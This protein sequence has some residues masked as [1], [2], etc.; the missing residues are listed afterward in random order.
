MAGGN[1][2]QVD[3]AELGTDANKFASVRRAPIVPRGPRVRRNADPDDVIESEYELYKEEVLRS[4]RGK[5]ASQKI[6]YAALD[7][8]GFYNQAWHTVYMMLAEGEEVDNR[9]G[10]LVTVAYRRA[11]DEFRAMHPDRQADVDALDVLSSETDLDAALDDRAKLHQFI[12]S[13]RGQL[14]ERELQ[15]AGLCYVYGY[16]RPEAAEVI[17]VRPQRMEKIM[18]SVSK[19]ISPFVSDIKAG[20]WCEAQSSLMN[21]YAFGLLDDDTVRYSLAVEHLKEC[22]A[23]RSD[24]LRKRGIAALV[25]PLPFLVIAGKAGAAVGVGGATAG[26]AAAGHSGGA[27]GGFSLASAASAVGVVGAVG[28]MTAAVVVSRP[29]ADSAKST[30]E[31]PAQLPAAATVI[32]SRSKAAVLPKKVHKAKK[33]KRKKHKAKAKAVQP[34]PVNVQQQPAAVTPEPVQQPVQQ[35]A[36]QKSQPKSPSSTDDGAGEF[37]LK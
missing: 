37:D 33:P 23:C 1:F 6:R 8:D 21:A 5:L 24:V 15:A 4:L 3:G 10:M 2:D 22:P 7:L 9:R 35:P 12:Q 11:V 17:G 27:G 36:P 26:A 25:A 29:L 28:V 19:K 18:D 34:A 14:T 31:N 13:L 32:H 16:T 20:E 30:A